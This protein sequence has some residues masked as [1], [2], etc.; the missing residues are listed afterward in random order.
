MED[1]KAKDVDAGDGKVKNNEPEKVKVEDTKAKD[2]D[3]GDGKVKNNEPE[4]VKAEDTKVKD[5]DAGDGKVKNNESEKVK[6]EDTK[7][8]DVDAGEGKVKNNEPEKVKTE[9]SNVRNNSTTNKET[10]NS[11]KITDEEV[12]K[13]IDRPKN[14]KD[15][16]ETFEYLSTANGKYGVDQGVLDDLYYFQTPDGKL[17]KKRS[18]EYDYYTTNNVQLKKVANQEYFRIKNMMSERYNMSARDASKVI[19]ALDSYGACSYADVANGIFTQF[20]DSPEIFEKIFGFPLYKQADNG[21]LAIND[22][23]LL[24]DIFVNVNNSKNGGKIFTT[25]AKGITKVNSTEIITDINNASK[26]VDGSTQQYLNS[27]NGY[28]NKLINEYI[29]SKTDKMGI[30]T[31]MLFQSYEPITNKQMNEIIKQAS[32]SLNKGESLG[33]GMIK[34]D[35]P[36]HFIDMETGKAAE[37][38]FNWNEGGGHATFITE[39][40]SDGFVVSTW[41]RKRLVLFSDLMNCGGFNINSLKIVGN[42]K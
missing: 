30:E 2:V 27:M 23:D 35:K 16:G 6:A 9:E 13:F 38:T 14:N 5:A 21:L 34:S 28:E 37:S 18:Y 10:Q 8:K 41:G 12:E 11:E 39:V 40:R 24:I 42:I 15:L 36:I 32:N 3:T 31:K 29:K 25:D 4:K 17:I 1:T 19:S 26:F 33:L 22:T 7:V 20:K